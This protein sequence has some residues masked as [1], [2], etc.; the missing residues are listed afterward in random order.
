MCGIT[1]IFN[2]QSSK[3]LRPIIQTMTDTLAHRGPNSDGFFTEQDKIALGHRRL[4]IIDLSTSAN[5]P[6]TDNSGRYVLV[7]NGEIY[8]YQE[9]KPLLPDYAFKTTSDTEVILAAYLKWGQDCLQ[10][11]NGMFAL[12]IWDKQQKQLFVARDRLGVKPFYYYLDGQTF[13]FASEIRSLLSSGLIARQVDRYALRD[14]LV[15]QSVYA[16]YTIIKDIFQLMPGECAFISAKGMEKSVYW[17]I[18]RPTQTFEMPDVTTVHRNVKDLLTASVQRR[19]ISDVPL[20]AF[21]SGGIDSSAIVGLMSE[22]SARPIDTFTVVFDEK[23]YDESYFAGVVAQR[24][25]T[26]HTKIRL[27][28]QDF[29]KALPEALDAMDAP[30]GDGLNTYIVSKMTKQAGITVALSGIG[31][32]E[33]FAG[34]PYFS[35][36]KKIQ[37]DYSLYWKIPAAI[38]KPNANLACCFLPNNDKYNRIAQLLK[39]DDSSVAAIYPIFR[40]IHAKDSAEKLLERHEISP[41]IIEQLLTE[42]KKAIAAFPTMSQFSIAELLGYTLNVL[43]RDTDQFSMAS[44]LEVREPFFDS[45]LVEYVLQVPDQFKHKNDSPKK[46]LV[47]ALHPLLPKQIVDRPKM[48]FSFPWKQWLLTDLRSFCQEHIDHLTK[49]DLFDA[50]ILQSEWKLF[51]NSKGQKVSWVKIWQ[52]VVLSNWLKKNQIENIDHYCDV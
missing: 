15:F 35:F 24:F 44:A 45:K 23:Q 12:A 51:L 26:H 29:L 31:G 1:G 20:G 19:M 14:Y 48:G 8:N 10:Y 28:S 17:A 39:A 4:S 3:P 40:L 43:L 33:L 18:E 21:L 36:F 42:R 13:L 6:F 37:T 11:L 27:T 16:P 5:Q 38:R 2:L 32:D 25:K 49:Y 46:L 30:S 9:I 52:L 47:D 50:K 7:F 41:L 22:V 34:Y